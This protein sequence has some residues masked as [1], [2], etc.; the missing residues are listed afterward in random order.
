[1]KFY[2]GNV[3]LVDL[4]TRQRHC[5]SDK[6]PNYTLFFVGSHVPKISCSHS[7]CIKC[8][9]SGKGPLT[10][11]YDAVVTSLVLFLEA[12]LWCGPTCK[13]V[14]V[15]RWAKHWTFCQSI[16]AR[17]SIFGKLNTPTIET[18]CT[19]WHQNRHM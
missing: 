6:K 16:L 3:F 13:M 18:F 7:P 10:R 15:V 14:S 4:Q 5:K 8:G 12:L 9:R 2:Q 17:H 11:F 19:Q 1:M